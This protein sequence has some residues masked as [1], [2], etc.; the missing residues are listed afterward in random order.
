MFGLGIYLADS[1]A[2]S[3]RYVSAPKMVDGRPVH[4]LLR[5]RV[6]LGNP[7]LI[8][9]GLKEEHSM[10]NFSWCRNPAEALTHVTQKWDGP[11]GHDAFYVKGLGHGA[12][13]GKAVVNSEYVVFHNHQV[14]P[15]YAVHYV[16]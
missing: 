15:L 8:E 3:H 4:T 14:L 12:K 7:Y 6:N 16:P 11:K 13:S 2:K 9:G 5:C 1:A 10:H